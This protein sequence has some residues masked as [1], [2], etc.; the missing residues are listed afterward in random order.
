[1][2]ATSATG[3]HSPAAGDPFADYYARESLSAATAARFRSTQ[4]AVLR[5]RRRLQ[6]NCE[7]LDVADIGC[8]AAMQCILWASTGH[9]ASGIDVNE[10][11]IEIGRKRVAEAQLDVKLEVGTATQLPWDS[12]SMDVCLMP[13]LLEHVPDWRLCLSEAV[14][15]LRPNGVLYLSTTNRL[16][17]VQSEFDLPLYSWY[18]GPLK[19]RCERLAVTTHPQWVNHAKFPAVNWFDYYSLRREPELQHLK[20][21]DRFDVTALADHG[22]LA[23]SVLRVLTASAPLRVL[24]HMATPYTAIFAVK[25]GDAGEV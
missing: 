23:Q 12:Q 2:K 20:C 17:P 4:S 1:M 9:K 8:G 13:E 19:R 6:L 22:A 11:L 24:A 3:A 14:R 21:F 18:P 15:I 5:L 7:R 16:C 10:P 25:R